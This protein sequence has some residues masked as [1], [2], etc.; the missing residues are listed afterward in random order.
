MSSEIDNVLISSL[1]NRK[2]DTNVHS[3]YNNNITPI[4]FVDKPLHKN[5]MKV[6]RGVGTCST[7]AAVPQLLKNGKQ[8]VK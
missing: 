4:K 3:N 8:T 7:V 6:V 2:F 1:N 5:V